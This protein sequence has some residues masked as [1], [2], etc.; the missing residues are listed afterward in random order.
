MCRLSVS[1]PGAETQV[2]I[3]VS[4]VVSAFFHHLST[5]NSQFSFA[6]LGPVSS[7]ISLAHAVSVMRIVKSSANRNISIQAICFC[8]PHCG[9]VFPSTA[10]AARGHAANRQSNNSVEVGVYDGVW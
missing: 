8:S 5:K 7:A 1:K 2:Y 4:H 9:V 6:V 10:A 3:L